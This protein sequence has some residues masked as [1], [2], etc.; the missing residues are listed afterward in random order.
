MLLI[1]S[2]HF[3]AQPMTKENFLSS[4]VFKSF[5]ER[6]LCVVENILSYKRKEF[7]NMC[8]L[9]EL[10]YCLSGCNS[11]VE[12]G[13]SILTMMLSDRK[14]KT[15]HDLINFCIVLKIKDK[16]WREKERSEALEIYL[17]KN[18]RKKIIKKD[19]PS[20]NHTVEVQ[21][22]GSKESHSHLS[23][24]DSYKFSGKENLT[25]NSLM[26]M[27]LWKI[28]FHVKFSIKNML[29]FVQKLIL[30]VMFFNNAFFILPIPF[31]F[32]IIKKCFLI[33]IVPTNTFLYIPSW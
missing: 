33:L 2:S 8:L 19:E 30:T 25:M 31:T 12:I 21:S 32:S 3:W 1:S 11:A 15:L 24:Y 9:A 7:P 4:C 5:P 26:K 14:L 6:N 28:I 20:S 22:S 29:I 17:S 16:N 13:F 27:N 23:D 10:M 18:R